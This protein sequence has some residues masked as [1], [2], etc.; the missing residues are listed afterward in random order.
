MSNL[1][2]F[3]GEHAYN[4]IQNTAVD[5]EALRAALITPQNAR[6]V[7]SELSEFEIKSLCTE[8][9]SSG[10]IG[11]VRTTSQAEIIA[12]FNAAG[13]DRVIFDD[14]QAIA[15]CRKYYAERETI[16]TYNNLGGRMREYHMMVAVKAGIDN[17]KRADD[18]QREDEYGTS[19]LNIQIAR[20]GSHMSIKNRYNH[21]VDQ[22]DST[23]NNNLDM[24]YMGLQSM[25]LGYYGFACLNNKKQH[26]AGIVNIGGI[27]L[28][29]H[30]ERN[31]IYFGAFV[32]DGTSGARYTDTS[33]YY[34]TQGDSRD[35][36]PLVLDFKNKTAIDLLNRNGKSPLITRA[37]KE[38]ILSSANK[39][40]ADYITATFPNAKKELL[41]ARHDALKYIAE[42]YG[43]DF[44]KPHNITAF[45]GKWTANS[46]SKATGESS[47]ILLIASDDDVS[48]CE[49]NSGKFDAKDLKSG[50]GRGIDR[51][52]SQGN[53]EEVRKSGTAA[54]YFV[55][56]SKKYRRTL[57]DSRDRVGVYMGTRGFVCFS[58]MTDTERAR[59]QLNQRLCV[60]KENKRKAEAQAHDYTA[61]VAEITESL[62]ELKSQL[63]AMMTSAETYEDYDKLSDVLDYRFKWLVR[64]VANIT[65]H[66]EERSFT[67]EEQ[68][69]GA[70]T[71][72]KNTIANLQSKLNTQCAA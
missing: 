26:Y 32:L 50:Y 12:A 70:I 71:E 72:A 11:Q 21:T 67:S 4:V 5:G 13:Y 47:G 34:V 65:K 43:Y 66:A 53:F 30:A 31:N 25:V 57:T 23:Y 16:C 56:Q 49:L 6:N 15:D 22:P 20:N 44:Q 37:L 39:E 28:K 35:Y 60:Y 52:Y 61:E 68:A 40:Q 17:I 33:R 29:Y 42:V 64:D 48:I 41:Q 54:A 24:I 7:F 55:T 38:G 46:I 1:K 2:K 3:V 45:C 51:F 19:V 59:I 8:I 62:S 9:S 63:V 69:N 18:P 27:Y 36:C 10:T 14:E 58:K